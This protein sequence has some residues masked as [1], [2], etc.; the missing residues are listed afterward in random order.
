MRGKNT[1]ADIAARKGLFRN[2]RY[3]V[4]PIVVIISRYVHVQSKRSFS[5]MK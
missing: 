3:P 4:T 1:M 5:F 2:K